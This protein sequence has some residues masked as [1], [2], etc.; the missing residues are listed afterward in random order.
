MITFPR[1]AWLFYMYLGY[2]GSERLNW[3]TAAK[4]IRLVSGHVLFQIGYRI[5]SIYKFY[6][7]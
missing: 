1:E 6:L 5:K 7:H 2:E 3:D 4:F